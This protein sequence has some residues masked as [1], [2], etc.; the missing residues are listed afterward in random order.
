MFF[1]SSNQFG[2]KKNP[3]VERGINYAQ[4]PASTQPSLMKSFKEINRMAKQ[5]IKNTALNNRPRLHIIIINA[6]STTNVF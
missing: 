6:F 1:F 2:G 5:N 4:Q 3:D